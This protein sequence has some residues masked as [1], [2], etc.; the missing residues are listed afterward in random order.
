MRCIARS[1]GSLLLAFSSLIALPAAGG[2]GVALDDAAAQ[3]LLERFAPL[4][5]LAPSEPVHPADVDWFLA[6]SRLDPDPWPQPKVTQASLLGDWAAILRARKR[7]V[8][9]LRPSPTAR[10]GSLDP[11]RWVTYG[12]V[13]PAAGDGLMLQF[14]FFYPFND[15]YFVFDH[16]GDWEHVTVRLDGALEPLGAYFARHGDNAPGRWSP[17]VALAREGEHPVVLSARGTHASYASPGD[18]RWYDRACSTRDPAQAERAGCSVWRT[19]D[20][21]RAGGVLLTGS[22]ERPRSGARFIAWPG[23][24]GATGHL[25]L[26]G[27]APLGPAFQRGWCAMGTADCR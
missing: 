25:G 4:V 22:R 7:N 14:W 20:R 24:W 3:A 17:W 18:V 16:E 5:L 27:G 15:G 21:G 13:Y 2:E 19:W 23:E 26:P 11:R 10:S 6:R 1:L 12:H 9:V 8:A